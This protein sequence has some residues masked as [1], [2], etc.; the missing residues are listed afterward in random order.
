MRQMQACPV[1][2]ELKLVNYYP[3][4]QMS[5]SQFKNFRKLLML[6]DKTIK[7]V[8]YSGVPGDCIIIAHEI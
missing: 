7:K 1:L 8:T 5:M 4:R 2:K 6:R 3:K